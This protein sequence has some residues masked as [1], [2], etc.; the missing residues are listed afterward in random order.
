MLFGSR[1]KA[2]VGLDSGVSCGRR[3]HAVFHSASLRKKPHRANRSARTAPASCRH[4]PCY[5]RC[6]IMPSLSD[7]ALA[8]AV[9]GLRRDRR[10]APA[11]RHVERSSALQNRFVLQTYPYAKPHPAA[12]T[13]GRPSPTWVFSSIFPV[14]PN[15]SRGIPSRRPQRYAFGSTPGAPTAPV[16]FFQ[17]K[18]EIFFPRR[19]SPSDI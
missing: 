6:P 4:G 15:L 8:A 2:G 14:L 10:A 11:G 12:L 13:R 1:Q 17:K 7:F 19:A 16:I 3:R 9:L 18:G 5:G